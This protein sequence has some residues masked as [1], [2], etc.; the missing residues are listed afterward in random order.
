M[1]LII[2]NDTN[3]EEKLIVLEEQASMPPSLSRRLLRRLA[4]VLAVIMPSFL[5]EKKKPSQSAQ[6]QKSRIVALQALRGIACLVV[7]NSHWSYAV[8]DPY[9]SVTGETMYDYIYHWPFLSL[10]HLGVVWVDV[11]FVLSGYVLS[12]SLLK[13]ILA[14]KPIGEVMGAGMTKRTVRI[15]LPAFGTLLIY[16]FAIQMDVFEISTQLRDVNSQ[17]HEFQLQLWEP[18]PPRMGSLFD[19]VVDVIKEAV[20]FIDPSTPSEAGAFERYDPH[21]CMS[22]VL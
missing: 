16:A 7:F 15:F 2:V 19:Q 17:T 22:H 11:L 4:S 10:I 20:K 5:H 18:L 1:S 3:D 9:G 8:S 12:L 21:L 14:R 6:S 13:L